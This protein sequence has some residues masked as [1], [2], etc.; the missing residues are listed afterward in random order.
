M[1]EWH[2]LTIKMT[3]E[4]YRMILPTGRRQAVLNSAD[5][6]LMLVTIDTGSKLKRGS[7]YSLDIKLVH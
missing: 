1:Q 4:T 2:P 6:Q 5:T 7:G 3:P